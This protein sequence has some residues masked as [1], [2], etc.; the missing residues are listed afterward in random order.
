M[1]KNKRKVIKIE[2]VSDGYKIF[3]ETDQKCLLAYTIHYGLLNFTEKELANTNR[4]GGYTAVYVEDSIIYAKDVSL[5]E[6]LVYIMIKSYCGISYEAYPSIELLADSSGHSHTTIIE[7]IDKLTEKGTISAIRSRRRNGS[8]Q[9][10]MNNLYKF[11]KADGSEYLT[12]V[13]LSI[14]FS[15]SLNINSKMLYIFLLAK[16]K[17]GYMVTVTKEEI[18]EYLCVRTWDTVK[19][20]IEILHRLGFIYTYCNVTKGPE[21][22]KGI[23]FL[24]RRICPR[25]LMI[26]DEDIDNVIGTEAVS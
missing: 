12:Y 23:R 21:K 18:K 25:E 11:K 8:D 10:Y 14:V 2:Q 13:P 7:A 16:A 6:K 4:I 24:L 3:Y 15:R 17:N 5:W 1:S 20:H 9:R 22:E 26:T 19:K